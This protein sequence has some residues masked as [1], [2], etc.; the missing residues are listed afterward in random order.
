LDVDAMLQGLRI[1]YLEQLKKEISKPLTLISFLLAYLLPAYSF[2]RMFGRTTD[3][4]SAAAILFSSGSEGSPK[5]IVLSHRNFMANI[6]QISDVLKTRDNDVVMGCLPPFHSFGLTVTTFLPLIEGIPVV[7]HPDPTDVV[8][9]AKA[10]SRNNVT[11][12]CATATFLRLYT[13]NK[14]VQPLMLDSLRIVVAGAEKLAMDV[15]EEFHDK[16]NKVI[17][18]GYGAT[19]TTPVASVNIPDQL[20]TN[21]WHVQVGSKIG[22]VGLPL[23]GCSFRIV[24]PATLQTLPANED[25]LILI[26]GTQVM[27]GYLNDAEKTKSVIAELDGRRWYKTGDKG[28]LDEDGFLTIVDRYSRFAKLGGEMVSLGAVESEIKKVIT[29]LDVELAA[30]NIPDE[31]KGEQVVLLTTLAIDSSELRKRLLEIKCSPMMIPSVVHHVAAIPKLGSGKTD[32][33]SA[34]ILAIELGLNQIT[35]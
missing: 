22:S 7:C 9:I 28:H 13:K 25:G 32:F 18:E 16:F 27:I 2:Y 31:K 17:Y 35:Q 6:K 15:R 33:S 24:D 20:D 5:G 34:K 19:E 11:I 12:M 30:V 14:K 21:D 4:N 29:E 3:I 8:N 10:I 26:S 23:P 1:I